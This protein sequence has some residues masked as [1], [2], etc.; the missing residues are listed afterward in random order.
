MSS[1]ALTENP[2]TVRTGR[3]RSFRLR[4]VPT[5]PFLVLAVIVFSAILAP[6]LT[7]YDPLKGKLIESLR[8]PEFLPVALPATRSARTVSVGTSLRG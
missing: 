8:P 6:L 1:T 7:P 3:A 4:L 5:I 2:A